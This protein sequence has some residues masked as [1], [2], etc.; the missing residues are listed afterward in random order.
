MGSA[1]GSSNNSPL[2]PIKNENFGLKLISA[3]QE[4]IF[5]EEELSPSV[6]NSLAPLKTR[7]KDENEEMNLKLQQNYKFFLS[8]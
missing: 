3:H 4:P 6:Y 8:L 1:V 2:P 5:D 7:K